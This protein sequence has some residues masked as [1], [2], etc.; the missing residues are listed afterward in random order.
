[1]A[2]DDLQAVSK[3][4]GGKDLH[5][6]VGQV[7]GDKVGLDAG[8]V[9]LLKEVDGHPQVYIAH[10]VDGQTHGVLAGIENT[11]LAGA[12]IL[13][14]QQVVAVIQS[15]HIFGLTSVNKLL[16]HGGI[17]PFI[18]NNFEGFAK[19]WLCQERITGPV[20][21][22]ASAPFRRSGRPFSPGR[23]PAWRPGH[24]QKRIGSG[25]PERRRFWLR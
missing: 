16:F 22:G 14:L 12:V 8:G 23:H 15:E 13:E 18:I 5:G 1:M 11:V 24:R 10:A 4:L 19:R 21:P 6:G 7:G 3:Y 9:D 17:P 2:A 25:R 20:R